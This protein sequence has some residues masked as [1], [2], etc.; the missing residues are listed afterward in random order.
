MFSVGRLWLGSFA[1]IFFLGS[2]GFFVSGITNQVIL[3]Y[4]VSVIYFMVNIGGSKYL[5][6]FALFQ[7][8]G[9]NYDFVPV[10]LTAAAV[11]A[12]SGILLREQSL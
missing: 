8:M 10:M 2:I 3:G 1:E 5:G 6:K 7:M 9:G 12:A 4:M 11:L